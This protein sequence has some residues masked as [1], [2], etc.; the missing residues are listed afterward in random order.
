MRVILFAVGLLALTVLGFIFGRSG[1]ASGPVQTVENTA[2]L[3]GDRVAAIA[4]NCAN[5]HGT[6][7]R[8]QTAIPSIAGKPES[9]LHAQ[10]LAFR[11]NGIPGAT[12]MP[13]LVKGYSEEELVALARYFAGLSPEED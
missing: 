5:C 2:G 1:E 13:R 6:G 12:V 9:V 4:V 3:S 7:G 8:L 11:A 10:L